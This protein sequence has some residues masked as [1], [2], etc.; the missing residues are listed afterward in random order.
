MKDLFLN[1]KSSKWLTDQ[2]E[3]WIP[4]QQ[5]I[6]KLHLWALFSM[7]ARNLIGF[8]QSAAFDRWIV[9]AEITLCSC[10]LL[11]V[12]YMQFVQHNKR[13][14]NIHFQVGCNYYSHSNIK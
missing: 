12:N 10:I 5:M 4:K 14:I 11:H 13:Q 6:M 7:S 8:G 9:H 3:K 1:F 2:I